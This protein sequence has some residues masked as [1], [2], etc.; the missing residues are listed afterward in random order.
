MTLEICRNLCFSA[1]QKVFIWNV[2]NFRI[3]SRFGTQ[4]HEESWPD[5]GGW[6]TKS[7]SQWS[8]SPAE[9]RKWTLRQTL[10]GARSVRAGTGVFLR[11]RCG[12]G[13]PK[14]WR[15]GDFFTVL[16]Q[17]F[18]PN[19]PKFFYLIYPNLYLYVLEALSLIK[20]H[21]FFIF[22]FGKQRKNFH[23][24]TG[25]LLFS[26]YYC[27]ILNLHFLTIDLDGRT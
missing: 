16:K 14:Q 7:Q 6:S 24:R 4:H 9:T 22:H 20:Y 26:V 8:C 17:I 21:N 27:Q 18:L 15:V 2:F 12:C 23:F 11:V 19:L 10:A 1:K 5:G 3:L 25:G 13:W